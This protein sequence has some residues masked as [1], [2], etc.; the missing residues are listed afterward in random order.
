M[1]NADSHTERFS[2]YFGR[3]PAEVSLITFDTDG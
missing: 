1:H 2:D 3:S